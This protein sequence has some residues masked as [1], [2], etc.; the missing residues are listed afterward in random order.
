MAKEINWDKYPIGTKFTA[1]INLIPTEG[2]IFKE[3]GRIYLLQNKADGGSALIKL[4]YKYSW[5]IDKYVSNLELTLDKDFNF[6]KYDIKIEL[7]TL[8]NGFYTLCAETNQISLIDPNPFG[9]CQNLSI[10]NA[11]K[12]FRLP[13]KYIQKVFNELLKIKPFSIIDIREEELENL[14]DDDNLYLFKTNYKSTNG[15]SMI[16]IGI[17]NDKMTKY[18]ETLTKL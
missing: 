17:N 5:R 14:P 10:V 3:N 16:I 4:G 11:Y 1:L 9:N 7:K 8:N 2:R 18:Y 13:K 15:N 12:I 6:D